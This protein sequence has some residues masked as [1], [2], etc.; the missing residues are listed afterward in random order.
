M[1]TFL[2][3]NDWNHPFWTSTTHRNLNLGQKVD[4][5]GGASVQVQKNGR[6]SGFRARIEIPK[7]G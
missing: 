6:I 2:M 7:V 3:G 4:F 1:N 5:E